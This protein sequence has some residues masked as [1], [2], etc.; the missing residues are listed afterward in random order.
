MRKIIIVNVWGISGIVLATFGL[1]GDTPLW[2]WVAC[3]LVALGLLNYMVLWKRA[4]QPDD[5]RPRK[6]S[7]PLVIYGCALLLIIDVLWSYLKR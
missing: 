1:P 5:Q 2:I 3:S 6:A 4:P 7:N